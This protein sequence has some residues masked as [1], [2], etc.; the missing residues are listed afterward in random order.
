MT[1]KRKPLKICKARRLN[2]QNLYNVEHPNAI[3]NSHLGMVGLHQNGNKL[4]ESLIRNF[5]D[6]PDTLIGN[7]NERVLKPSPFLLVHHSFGIGQYRLFKA[8][9]YILVSFV[10]YHHLGIIYIHL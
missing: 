9:W 6:K 1:Q 8:I 7:L 2:H 3:N 10:T 5:N 4:P